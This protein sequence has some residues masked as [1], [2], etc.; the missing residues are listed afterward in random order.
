MVGNSPNGGILVLLISPMIVDTCKWPMF[1]HKITKQAHPVVGKATFVKLR[2]NIPRHFQMNDDDNSSANTT[3]KSSTKQ[4]A[5]MEDRI[6][7]KQM[8][9][10]QIAL[11]ED[12][13]S[14]WNMNGSVPILT[15][16]G[17]GEYLSHNLGVN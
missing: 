16:T 6:W 2:L 11:M 17:R 7:T 10:K 9:S 8:S 15:F 3:L 13:I 5:L 12:R 4:I 14:S 1:Q